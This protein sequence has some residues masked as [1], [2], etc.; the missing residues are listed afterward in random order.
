MADVQKS[1]VTQFHQS[2]TNR[3]LDEVLDILPLLEDTD[4][5]YLCS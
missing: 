5:I 2:V 1:L 3:N 4:S